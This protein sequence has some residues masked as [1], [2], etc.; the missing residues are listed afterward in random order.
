MFCAFR[1]SRLACTETARRFRVFVMSE[2]EIIRLNIE[3]YRR[4]LKIEADE[5]MRRVI[6]RMLEEFEAKLASL[7]P[8]AAGP[9]QR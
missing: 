8:R 1:N 2:I 5:S 4:M 7:K 3:R 6:Q 9:R